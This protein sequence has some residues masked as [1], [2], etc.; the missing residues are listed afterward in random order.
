MTK[1][2]KHLLLPIALIGA[3]MAIAYS[4]ASSRD[5]VP[6]RGSA[7][8]PPS[9]EIL[10]V[11]PGPV[12]VTIHSRGVVR[13]LRS[14][15]LVSE[16][17][18]R[19]VWVDP[20][21]LQGEL[22]SEGQL[23][24]NIDPIDYEVA[25]SDARAAVA[26]AELALAEVVAIVRKAAIAEAEARLAAAK[27][28]LSQAERDLADTQI[29]APYDAIVDSKQ[30]DL[31]QYVQTGTP[32]MRLLSTDIAEVRLPIVGADVPFVLAGEQANGQ[33]P[34]ANL[35]ATLGSRTEEWR[36]RLVR[37][38][39][40][41]DEQT[42]VSF[43]VGQ[44]DQPYDTS[45]HPNPLTLGL[46]VEASF[47]GTTIDNAVRLPRPALHESEYVY[48]VRDGHLQRLYVDL[49][50]QEADSVIVRGDF[51][52]GDRVVTNRLDLMVDGMTVRA[53]S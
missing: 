38:E 24:L 4:L 6:R 19:V 39:R 14:I 47:S 21:F 49:L 16:V 35:I 11:K 37:L 27:D 9:V 46:F 44:V 17:S 31:G 26:T 45:R 48:L 40:R 10:E 23:L 30:V 20:G 7:A 15:D 33:W 42:R 5:D 12:A 18:G 22:I 25:L 34:E 36:A 28:R 53:S 8:P 43:L 51:N 29:R 50:R 41:V 13:P 52:S 3:A 2:V 32:L 1:T